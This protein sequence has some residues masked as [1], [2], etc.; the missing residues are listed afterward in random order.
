MSAC[1]CLPRGCVH[2]RTQGRYPPPPRGPTDTPVKHYL[3]ATTV[4][5]GK[6]KC[7]IHKL[8]SGT[9]VGVCALCEYC[10]KPDSVNALNL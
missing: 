1:G 2:A 3:F 10:L 8:F 4:A 7:R 9:E 6:Y 5:D